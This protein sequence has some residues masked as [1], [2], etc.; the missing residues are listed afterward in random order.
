MGLSIWY[1]RILIVADQYQTNGVEMEEKSWM[2]KLCF[3]SSR[4]SIH[5]SIF[6]F[7]FKDFLV[8]KLNAYGQGINRFWAG[9]I[10]ANYKWI[11][12]NW[13]KWK[14]TETK[15]CPL[16]SARLWALTWQ[17]NH[18]DTSSEVQN[19][20]DMIQCIKC[21]SMWGRR[22]QCDGIQFYQIAYLPREP[23]EHHP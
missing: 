23:L 17:A 20:N 14:K 7:F 10:R 12:G 1:Y 22:L 19:L 11:E 16:W 9:L 18:R 8:L 21:S 5:S 13:R 6:N 15:R 3:T 2:F 4:C